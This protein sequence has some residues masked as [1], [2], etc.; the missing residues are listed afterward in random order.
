MHS[1]TH[2]SLNSAFI[3]EDSLRKVKIQLYLKRSTFAW[4][5]EKQPY[6]NLNKINQLTSIKINETSDNNVDVEE[7]HSILMVN[8]CFKA[9]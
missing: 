1:W 4:I 3:S 6:I 7:L 5:K 8:L 2:S 9:Y